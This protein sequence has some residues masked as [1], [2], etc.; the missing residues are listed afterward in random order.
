M[1]DDPSWACFYDR[2]NFLLYLSIKQRAFL[3]Q[4]KNSIPK[5]THNRN[6]ILKSKI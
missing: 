6:V 2:K 1:V 5:M 4:L 3:Y